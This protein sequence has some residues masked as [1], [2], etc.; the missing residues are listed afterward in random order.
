MRSAA[1]QVVV[2]TTRSQSSHEVLAERLLA[3]QE[4]IDLACGNTVRLKPDTPH[5][6]WGDDTYFFCSAICRRRFAAL[7]PAYL[8]ENDNSEKSHCH[9]DKHAAA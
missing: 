9:G 8:F 6:R 7:L 2:N 5:L 1:H 3:G 4:V